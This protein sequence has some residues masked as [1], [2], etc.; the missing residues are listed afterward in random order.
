[1]TSH[2]DNIAQPHLCRYQE[3]CIKLCNLAQYR[4]V[5]LS[6]FCLAASG[7]CVLCCSTLCIIRASVSAVCYEALQY[8]LPNAISQPFLWLNTDVSFDISADASQVIEQSPC[9]LSVYLICGL[10][11][12]YHFCTSPTLGELWP[13]V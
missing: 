1:M 7:L 5:S 11:F 6:T 10:P 13:V 2:M 3:V 9:S 8:T 12:H 4:L